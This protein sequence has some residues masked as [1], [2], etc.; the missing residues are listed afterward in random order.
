[1]RL[2]IDQF[3]SR[4]QQTLLTSVDVISDLGHFLSPFFIVG[5][6]NMNQNPII[7]ANW[8]RLILGTVP[9]FF[10]VERKIE[11]TRE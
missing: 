2:K 3:P 7:V 5:V 1:M 10:L 8:L 11:I 4:Y 9:A 6:G